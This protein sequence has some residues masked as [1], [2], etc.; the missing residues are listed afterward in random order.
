MPRN[1][2]NGQVAA[3]VPANSTSPAAL[4][5]LLVDVREAARLLAC[6]ERT[7]WGLTSPRGPIPSVKIG[8]RS[9]RYSVAD[10]Q[11]FVDAQKK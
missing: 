10:L 5:P 2:A 3:A 9:V 7:L 8:R 11:A 4:Q 6:S 1:E